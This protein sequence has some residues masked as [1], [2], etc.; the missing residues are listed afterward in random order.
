MDAAPKWVAV[1]PCSALALA[2]SG[3]TS[4]VGRLCFFYV[5]G[6]PKAQNFCRHQ[7]TTSSLTPGRWSRTSRL[8]IPVIVACLKPWDLRCHR[9]LRKHGNGLPEE[10]YMVSAAHHFGKAYYSCCV[11]KRPGQSQLGKW[12]HVAPAP[13]SL[14]SLYSGR[15]FPTEW[16]DTVH[17]RNI[18]LKR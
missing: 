18:I 3:C 1:V 17:R 7:R 15:L 9:F 14:V 2:S 13:C 8:Y 16:L 6:C 5:L 11:G 4:E 10:R 12:R